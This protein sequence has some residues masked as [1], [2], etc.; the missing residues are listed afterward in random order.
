MAYANDLDPTK[1][2]DT[3][4][5][6]EGDDRIRET[7]AGIEERLQT[8][9]S[10][11][12]DSDPLI[13]DG[14]IQLEHGLLVARPASP[15]P[16][17][18]YYATD[19]GEIFLADDSASPQWK[20]ANSWVRSGVVADRPV[21][22]HDGQLYYATDEKKLY[23]SNGGTWDVVAGGTGTS[24][25]GGSTSTSVAEWLQ[26]D[27][28]QAVGSKAVLTAQVSKIVT[29][30]VKGTTDANSEVF[31]NDSELPGISLFPGFVVGA[32]LRVDPPGVSGIAL[33]AAH[34]ETGISFASSLRAKISDTA[35][36]VFVGAVV[37]F[38]VTVAIVNLATQT[39]P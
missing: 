11:Y 35:G 32:A 13:L 24:S 4:L 19:T 3:D 23:A 34:I 17:Q 9:F 18:V 29:I 33:I 30:H 16:G 15:L 5:A 22:D 21:P 14:R 7:R 8:A 37:E 25:G 20:H 27:D 10:G 1:P 38:V 36:S 26:Y 6:S 28:A 2:A 39:A 12:P 31:V